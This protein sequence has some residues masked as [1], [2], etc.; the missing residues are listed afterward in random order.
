MAAEPP[1]NKRHATY[2]L[3]VMFSILL[4]GRDRENWRKASMLEQLLT[5]NVPQFRQTLMSIRLGERCEDRHRP[6][7]RESDAA[8]LDQCKRASRTNLTS[9]FGI[10]LQ[11]TAA[12]ATVFLVR[13]F[14]RAPAT[15]D[16]N[17][18][19]NHLLRD[20]GMSLTDVDFLVSHGGRYRD[21]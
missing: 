17:A 18:M 10:L 16:F 3:T 9:A 20:I 21:L 4:L 19:N 13:L 2:V 12:A 6:T 1:G 7:G 15:A 8:P 14:R 5:G 11:R